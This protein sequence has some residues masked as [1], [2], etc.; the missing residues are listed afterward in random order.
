MENKYYTPSIEEFHVGF[1]FEK[2][3]YTF[4]FI[5]DY[6]RGKSYYDLVELSK[7]DS[8][9]KY[10]LAWVPVM[11]NHNISDSVLWMYLPF[12]S[13]SKKYVNP[14]DNLRVKYL[15]SD[16][17]ESLGFVFARYLEESAVLQFSYNEFTLNYEPEYNDLEIYTVCDG[18]DVYQK[19]SGI[20]K[21]KSE[22]VVLLKQIGIL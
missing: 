13:K 2:L 16:D 22:L 1:E 7:T 15:D 10:S 6:L 17:I 14:E 4:E 8:N 19:F 3:I 12:R 18:F 9:I 20:I 21:N 5:P 11:T